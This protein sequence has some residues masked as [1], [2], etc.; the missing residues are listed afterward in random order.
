MST[1]QPQT[2]PTE[3]GGNVVYAPGT[4]ASIRDTTSNHCK[5]GHASSAR[6]WPSGV[7][8][9]PPRVASANQQD[10]RLYGMMILTMPDDQVE[11]VDT[12][13]TPDKL[14]W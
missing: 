3:K 11:R 8:S 7:Q 14:H 2:H 4:W 5:N 9:I 12:V 10:A 1:Y 13:L 6:S